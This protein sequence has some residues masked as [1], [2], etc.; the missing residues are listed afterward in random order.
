MLF[1]AS[2][3]WIFQVSDKSRGH[4]MKVLFIFV[5]LLFIT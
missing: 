5:G 2:A 1:P 4:K 3:I